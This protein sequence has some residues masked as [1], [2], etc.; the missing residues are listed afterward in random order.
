M[1]EGVLEIPR[2]L[3]LA[4]AKDRAALIKACQELPELRLLAERHLEDYLR[5]F[6]APEW[7]RVH[8]GGQVGSPASAGGKHRLGFSIER[9][10]EVA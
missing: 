8:S 1:A 5:W 7:R 2:V 3:D 4:A 10:L 9:L 6:R